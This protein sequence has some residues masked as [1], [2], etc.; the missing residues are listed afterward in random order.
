MSQSQGAQGRE[1]VSAQVTGTRGPALAGEFRHSIYP[2]HV[3]CRWGVGL[4]LLVLAAG[5]PQGLLVSARLGPPVAYGPLL[6]WL[7]SHRFL[8][9]VAYVIFALVVTAWGRLTRWAQDFWDDLLDWG[10]GSSWPV[11]AALLPSGLPLSSGFLKDSGHVLAYRISIAVLLVAI[12]AVQ[13]Y[14]QALEKRRREAGEDAV[15]RIGAGVARI[16]AGIEEQSKPA[17][18]PGKSFTFGLSLRAGK[19]ESGDTDD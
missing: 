7:D 8:L 17:Q 2:L 13:I 1:R 3:V 9:L 18:A 11:L 5:L 19:A 16:A 15:N 6:L 4:D 10:P 12:A 14:G